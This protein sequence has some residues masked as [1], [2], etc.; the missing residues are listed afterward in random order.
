[1]PALLVPLES[2]LSWGWSS[3][4]RLNVYAIYT[5]PSRTGLDCCKSKSLRFV[6]GG[7]P[8]TSALWGVYDYEVSMFE[9]TLS[10]CVNRQRLTQLSPTTVISL[11][12]QD[13][14]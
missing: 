1:M 10:L 3:G 2:V 12:Q 14:I 6:M 4:M 9:G 13:A 8:N 5:D 11:E 7:P